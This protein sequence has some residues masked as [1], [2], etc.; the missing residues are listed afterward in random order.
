MNEIVTYRDTTHDFYISTSFVS[1]REVLK[2]PREQVTLL[3][4]SLAVNVVIIGC[5][6]ITNGT[7]SMT[8]A[9]KIFILEQSKNIDGI[10]LHD[11][12]RGKMFFLLISSFTNS[13][14]GSQNYT[15]PSSRV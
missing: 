1:R 13:F 9:T 2:C 10:P 15:H 14:Y 8:R 6:Y 4:I 12:N 7:R 3:P 11:N 5:N